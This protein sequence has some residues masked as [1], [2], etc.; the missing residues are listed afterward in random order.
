[1]HPSREATETQRNAN[2]TIS[3]TPA[4]SGIWSMMSYQ[5]RLMIRIP[6]KARWCSQRYLINSVNLAGKYLFSS[7]CAV[8]WPTKESLLLF[9]V[10][11]LYVPFYEWGAQ[12]LWKS[13]VVVR[14]IWRFAGWS[15]FTSHAVLKAD[16]PW[17]FFCQNAQ[18]CFFY[19]NHTSHN[20][21]TSH[22]TIISFYLE[23]HYRC[24]GWNWDTILGWKSGTLM[25]RKETLS[26]PRQETLAIS[27]RNEKGGR[28]EENE[29]NREGSI[30]MKSAKGTATTEDPR[31]TP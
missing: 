5:R 27:K 2:F 29:L 6:K 23:Q 25:T 12:T 15:L 20:A 21:D 24:F 8:V 13:K 9:Q 26:Q 16:L 22:L 30:K 14:F 28:D 11:V 4:C 19:W 31:E 3:R 1:M 10:N 18:M 17:Q 7:F